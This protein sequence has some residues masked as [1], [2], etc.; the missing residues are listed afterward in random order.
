MIILLP[1]F[2]GHIYI[3]SNMKLSGWHARIILIRSFKIK[4]LN[5]VVKDKAHVIH[6][7]LHPL[8]T[9][10]KRPKA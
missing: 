2:G 1:F 3:V 10:V 4:A 6:C 8:F 9:G 7:D 5:V